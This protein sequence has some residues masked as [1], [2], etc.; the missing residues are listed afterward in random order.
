MGEIISRTS[1]DLGDN[2]VE[3]LLGAIYHRFVML[4]PVYVEA[5]AGAATTDSGD[6][7]FTVDFAANGFGPGLGTGKLATYP[8]NGQGN[9]RLSVNSDEEEPDPV[10]SARIV[11]YPISIHANL[12]TTIVIQSFTVRPRDANDDLEVQLLDKQTDANVGYESYA[13]IIPLSPLSATTT[14]DV[15]FVGTVDAVA[16][17]STW[18]FTTADE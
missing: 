3:D 11:G 16:V 8:F 5:G 14:Y 15:H 2:A 7:Y 10:P 13:A 12:G 18:S 4:E 1:N 9:V 6:T 17:D